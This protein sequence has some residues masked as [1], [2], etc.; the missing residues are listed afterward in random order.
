MQKL[1]FKIEI[2]APAQKVYEMMLGLNTKETYE[3][4]TAIFN[5]T[6]TYEGSWEEGSNMR[7]V[8]TDDK[9]KKG[10]MLA[11]IVENKPANFVSIRN[12]G[13]LDGDNEVTE[14]K[15]VDKWTGGHENYYFKE[16]NGTTVLTVE[17]DTIDDYADYFNET[18]PKALD[19]LKEIAEG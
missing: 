16:N 8:G 1:I 18:Y 11:E 3:K 17:L 13:I 14:G 10:G 7:F 5:P 2:N 15:E 4:W 12:Y 19:K 9:G 6:S